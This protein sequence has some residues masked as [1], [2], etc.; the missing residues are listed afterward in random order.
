M[1][2]IM[3]ANTFYIRTISSYIS[4]GNIMKANT[5]YMKTITACISMVNIKK[6]NTVCIK[7]AAVDKGMAISRKSQWIKE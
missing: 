1:F 7:I 5:V 6:A 3:K 4:T 2:N